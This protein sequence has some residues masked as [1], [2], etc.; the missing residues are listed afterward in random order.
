MFSSIKQE[1]TI[2]R[3]G[4]GMTVYRRLYLC[5]AE[6]DIPA[7]PADDAP[8]SVAVVADGGGVYMLDHG[9]VW[10]AAGTGGAVW[11]V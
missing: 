4:R 1:K 7:L 5:D 3:D 9:R 11:L 2:L 6:A 8:G 10:R